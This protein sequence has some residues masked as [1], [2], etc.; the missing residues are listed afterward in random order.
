M[1]AEVAT[2]RRATAAVGEGGQR[3]RGF[4]A[5]AAHETREK[6]QKLRDSIREADSARVLLQDRLHTE[7]E[8]LETVL[9]KLAELEAI[10][11]KVAGLSAK[12]DAAAP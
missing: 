3:V 5:S 12:P 7:Q 8:Q 6:L 1:N 9:K 2:S 10:C 4:R 11:R